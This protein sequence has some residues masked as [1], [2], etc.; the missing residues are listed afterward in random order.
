[1]DRV[2]TLS[3][4]QKSFLNISGNLKTGEICEDCF[5]ELRDWVKSKRGIN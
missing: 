4:G 1:M 3:Y 2:Y 5:K